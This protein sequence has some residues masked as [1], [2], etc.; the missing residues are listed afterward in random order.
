MLY[1]K[2]VRKEGNKIL[3]D[4][5]PEHSEVSAPISLDGTDWDSFK[6]TLVGHELESNGH[7]LM[8][9]RALYGMATGAREI[10]DCQIMWY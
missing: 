1:L 8:A 3:A 4:Y 6:G 10:E 7:L 5:Y 2:N 9:K